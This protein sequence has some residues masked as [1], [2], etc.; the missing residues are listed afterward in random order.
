MSGA[1]SIWAATAALAISGCAGNAARVDIA[2]EVSAKSAD[3]MRSVAAHYDEIEQRRR[4]T[5][6]TVVA[7]DPSCLPTM[8]LTVQSPDKPRGRQGPLCPTQGEAAGHSSYD[9]DFSPTPDNVLKPRLVLIAAVVD[10]GTALAKIVADP[11]ADIKGDL[12][13]FAQKVDRVGSLLSFVSGQDLPSVGGQLESEEGKAI[14]NLLDF[15]ITLQHEAD[16][17]KRVHMLVRGNGDTVDAAL[18]EMTEQIDTWARGDLSGIQYEHTAALE[19]AYRNSRYRMSFA[20]RQATAQSIFEAR[21]EEALLPQRTEIVLAAVGEVQAAQQELRDALSG[22]FSE[23]RR[24]QIAKENIDRLTR[25]ME[26][27][28]SLGRA[29]I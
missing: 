22:R 9:L 2:R 5:A 3:A 4:R 27:V 20:E 14:A 26:L 24:R 1:K 29:F 10:Y 23:K 28:A 13:A 12:T 16:Q 21:G 25:A 15:A 17:V 19:R 8:P 18:A 11:K 6:A 7:S